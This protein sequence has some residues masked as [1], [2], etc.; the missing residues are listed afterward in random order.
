MKGMTSRDEQDLRRIRAGLAFGLCYVT[1]QSIDRK[2]HDGITHPKSY[3]RLV[4]VLQEFFDQDDDAWAFPFA[5]LTGHMTNQGLLPLPPGVEPEKGFDRFYDG[6]Q[7]YREV[8]RAS[9][10]K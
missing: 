7:C 10:K 5:I 3:D 1:A 2:N 9:D 6:V 4:D 8:I